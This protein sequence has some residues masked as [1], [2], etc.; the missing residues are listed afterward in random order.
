MLLHILQLNIYACT[1]FD[2]IQKFFKENSFDILQFQEVCG[3]GTRV[4]NIV[5][6]RNNLEEL[7]T[8]LG[9]TYHSELIKRSLFT[10]SP[11][12]Y[13]AN[14]TFWKDTLREVKKEIIWLNKTDKPFPSEEKDFST[15]GTAALALQFVI[16]DRPIWFINTHG[17]WSKSEKDTLAKEQQ[18]ALLVDFIKKLAE[19]FIL[20]G[21]FN[22]GNTT[23]TIQ[24]L[25]KYSR[26]LAKEYGLTNTLNPRLHR[27]KVFPPGLAVDFIF[28]SPRVAVKD[29]TL[30]D[31]DLSD[32]LGLAVTI[33][34]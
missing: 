30:I 16:N 5:C 14:A 25:E 26:N 23:R 2:N 11:T 32:H 27:A 9:S 29:F 20:T 18:A 28:T 6:N 15:M 31:E 24:L 34:V 19:P 7:Q 3:K 21:D 17:A 22:A 33:E 1:Y 13:E 12:A 4:G 8:L 10:S